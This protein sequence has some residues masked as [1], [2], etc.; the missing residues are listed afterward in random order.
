MTRA[1][2]LERLDIETPDVL[3]EAFDHL[4]HGRGVLFLG[5]HLGAL[6]L[7]A[8]Y[9]VERSPVPVNAPMETIDNPPLQ[10]WL[11]RVRSHSGIR[12]VPLERASQVLRTALRR[13][14]FVAVVADRDVL[15]TGQTATFFGRPARFPVGGALL[16][17]ASS[18]PVYAE[19]MRRVDGGRY[20]ARIVRLDPVPAGGALRERVAAFLQ[21]QATAYERLIADAPDQWWSALFRIWTSDQPDGA[22][23]PGPRS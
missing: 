23:A 14:E 12:L 6:E 22:P 19:A 21:A 17:L 3:D 16:G 9:V 18:A 11:T 2:L 15:G 20:A 8:L 5:L 1:E 10:A 7:P 13:G 4:A